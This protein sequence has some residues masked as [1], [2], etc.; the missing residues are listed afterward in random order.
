[1]K[2]P[3]Q[4][5]RGDNGE[6]LIEDVVSRYASIAEELDIS[7]SVI[8]G[9]HENLMAL[10]HADQTNPKRYLDALKAGGEDNNAKLVAG[11]FQSLGV[12]A[13]Y[14]NPKKA[15]LIV[16]DEGG[17]TRVLPESYDRLYA[18]RDEPGI[19]VFP[20]FFGYT[21]DGDVLTFSRSSSDITG[22]ILANGV[23]S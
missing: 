23:K 11:Y 12:E 3:E 15:G 5:L 9:I 22:S 21:L 6:H 19:V 2:L 20:G 1:M 4:Q 14:I 7:E 17:F 18:L 8:T 13:Q 16:T 10:L